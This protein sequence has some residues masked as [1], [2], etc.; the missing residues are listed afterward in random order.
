MWNANAEIAEFFIFAEQC[1]L[2]E[3]IAGFWIQW[4]DAQHFVRMATIMWRFTWHPNIANIFLSEVEVRAVDHL[5]SVKKRILVKDVQ[6]WTLCISA[7]QSIIYRYKSDIHRFIIDCCSLRG[8]LP[9]DA[10][11]CNALLD[12]VYGLVHVVAIC[13]DSYAHPNYRHNVPYFLHSVEN[14]IVKGIFLS[15]MQF[16]LQ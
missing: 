13:L 9:R 14:K 10:V 11:K 12:W 6:K 3:F 16:T 15:E 8:F 2:D 4:A 1:F 7:H 5:L